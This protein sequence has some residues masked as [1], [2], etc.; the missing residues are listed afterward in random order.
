MSLAPNA[1]VG[2][3]VV[4]WDPELVERVSGLERGDEPSRLLAASGPGFSG[5][6][7]IIVF[8][9]NLRVFAARRLADARL[10]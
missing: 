5:L 1:S 2:G 3:L 4:L 6:Q 8:W 7:R 10:G 9:H